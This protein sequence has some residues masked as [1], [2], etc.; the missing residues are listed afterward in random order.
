ML[1]LQCVE[2]KKR[3]AEKSLNGAAG[4][5][6]IN[7]PAASLHMKG[8]WD[9]SLATEPAVWHCPYHYFRGAHWALVANDS[10]NRWIDKMFTHE[11][12]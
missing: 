4:A 11:V 12:C 2:R 3:Y 7:S 6:V 8:A 1:Y 9:E 10:Q 5:D